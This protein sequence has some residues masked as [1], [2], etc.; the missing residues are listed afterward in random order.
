MPFIYVMLSQTGTSGSR[1]FKLIT[2]EPYNHSSIAFDMELREMYSFGRRVM[3]NQF[4]AG[5]VSEDPDT[6]VFKRFKNTVCRI[7]EIPVTNEQYKELKRLMRE[8]FLPE[9]EKYKYDFVGLPLKKLSIN[10]SRKYRYVCSHF[11]ASMIERAG[12]H[13]FSKDPFFIYPYHFDE[14]KDAKIIYEGLLTEYKRGHFSKKD[15]YGAACTAD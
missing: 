8:E 9:M 13:Q 15:A 11:V 3:Y 10:Y 1:F 2:K 5:L 4:I 12:I 6:F 14:I 7:Y